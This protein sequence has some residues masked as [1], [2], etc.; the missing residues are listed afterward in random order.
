G[1]EVAIEVETLE[2]R[3]HLDRDAVVVLDA[4]FREQAVERTVGGRVHGIAAGQ[5]PPPLP[6]LPPGAGPVLVA[7]RGQPGGRRDGLDLEPI[8]RFL[9]RIGANARTDEAPLL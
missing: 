7:P 5:E 9:P 6:V 4:P 2:R 3:C 1:R 8:L